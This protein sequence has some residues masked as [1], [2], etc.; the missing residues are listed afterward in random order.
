MTEEKKIEEVSSPPVE[1]IEVVAEKKP[2]IINNTNI[3]NNINI[4][5]YMHVK[6]ELPKD[7]EVMEIED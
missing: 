4:T 5:N 7:D 6:P 1:E 3:T 2:K